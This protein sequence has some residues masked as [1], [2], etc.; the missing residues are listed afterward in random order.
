MP[1]QAP[2]PSSGR[3]G[4]RRG[5]SR[6]SRRRRSAR[7]RRRRPGPRGRR[8]APISLEVV[9]RS[10]VRGRPGGRRGCPPGR[11]GSA[12]ADGGHHHA[13][14]VELAQAGGERPVLV[15]RAHAAA[16]DPAAAGDDHQVGA[17]AQALGA[18]RR[19]PWPATISPGPWAPTSSTSR[20]SGA[21]RRRWQAPR[22]GRWRRPRRSPRRR[23]SRFACP[24]WSRRRAVARQWQECHSPQGCR[25]SPCSPSRGRGLRPGAGLPRLRVGA[26]TRCRSAGRP[27]PLPGRST[28]SHGIG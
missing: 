22:T 1:S 3:R 6:T 23:R 5:R 2:R 16:A 12:G 27:R 17:L 25:Q 21:C 13:A 4:G 11:A 14:V 8:R 7:R 18:Q 24:A 15:L 10:A 26:A 28:W 9:E 19:M 20:S